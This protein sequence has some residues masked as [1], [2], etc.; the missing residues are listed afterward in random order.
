[1]RTRVFFS[2]LGVV[3]GAA[4]ALPSDVPLTNWTVPPYRT[5]TASGGLSTMVDLSPGIG[6]VAV[7]PCRIVDTRGGG[8][9]TGTYGPPAL[10][11]NAAARVFDINSA[12]HC[13]GI[14]AG[15]DAYSLNFTVIAAAGAFQ[16][17][18]LTAWPTG[19]AQPAVSTL[20][21]NAGQLVANAA[22]VPAGTNGSINVFVNAPGHLLIDINGYFTDEYNPGTPF[23]AV[24]SG[25]G[26][27]I[28][29]E[30]TAT[31]ADAVAI[32]GVISS[33]QAGS[34]SVAV[35]GINEGM[36][37]ESTGVTGVWGHTLST[38]TNAAGVYGIAG[39]APPHQVLPAGVRG[40]SEH[41]HGVLGISQN[42]RGVVGSSEGASGVVGA[43]V[44]GGVS[45]SI[46]HLGFSP[47]TG[48]FSNGDIDATGK[49]MFVEPHPTDPTRQIGY[50]SLEG[51]EAGTY[52]RGKGKFQRGTAVI[53]VPES[54]RLVT[55]PEGLSI[56]ITPVG[57]MATVAV[58][59]LD[60]GRIV[61]KGSRDVEFFY[62][63][64]GVR[65]AFRNHQA[66][67]RNEYYVPEGPSDRMPGA[68]APEQRRRLIAT[69][70]YNADGTVNMETARRLGWEKEWEKRERP[71]PQPAD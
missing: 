59:S 69:G 25:T 6:F 4:M 56:Q 13:P 7:T 31:G 51:P 27:A 28:L 68:Y 65:Q 17:A 36:T 24:S 42:W 9:F 38:H 18:F 66:I 63:V 60:L 46:G 14:P 33:S 49:K 50:V 26:P 5:S 41:G 16:N 48:V 53:A 22:I 70:I 1:M 11:G 15:A 64:N 40:A 54:F 30:N 8:V 61:V 57:E 45:Q 23:S 3:S 21:F 67:Q 71:T 34:N 32:R 62:T 19:G 37:T 43:R 2:L 29:G 12:A 44:S 35:L 52:F 39:S 58:V 55:D 10:V 20:N 47:T